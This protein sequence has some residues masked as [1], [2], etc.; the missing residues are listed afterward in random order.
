MP[1]QPPPLTPTRKD[2]DGSKPG[3]LN[4]RFISFIAPSVKV[5][6]VVIIASILQK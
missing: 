3:S 5:T 6:G 2:C 1:E 4:N